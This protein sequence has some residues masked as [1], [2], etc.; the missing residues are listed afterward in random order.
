MS[1]MCAI[2][3]HGLSALENAYVGPINLIV[4][5]AGPS[6]RSGFGD[7]FVKVALAAVEAEESLAGIG[8]VEDDL[9]VFFKF[10]SSRGHK[11]TLLREEVSAVLCIMPVV[12]ANTIGRV[13]VASPSKV[14]LDGD[15][16]CAMSLLAHDLFVSHDD[17]GTIL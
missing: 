4:A 11:P 15:G 10:L 14:I 1:Q 8:I 16:R 3:A 2:D 6:V 12:I 5:E 7:E 9:A 13:T 17:R